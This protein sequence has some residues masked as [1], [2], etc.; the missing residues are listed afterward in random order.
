MCQPDKLSDKSLLRDR[1]LIGGEWLRAVAAQ[2]HRAFLCGLRASGRKGSIGKTNREARSRWLDL[3]I[4]N[5]DDLA[6]IMTP[7]QAKPLAKSRSEIA[8]AAS[9]I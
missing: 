3:M 8:Y 9:F 2:D 6:A 5:Q 1:C 7:E 4:A